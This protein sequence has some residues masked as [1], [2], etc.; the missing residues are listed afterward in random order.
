MKAIIL[1][2]GRG[3]RMG[4]LTADHPKGMI[5]VKGKSLLEWQMEALRKAGVHD[6]CIVRGYLGHAIPFRDVVYRE[7][8]QWESTNMVSSLLAASDVLQS[9]SC[10]V[11]YAD[12]IY[13]DSTVE[14]LLT[15]AGNIRIT[16]DVNWRDLWQRR[17]ANPL[18]DAE[19][20]RLHPDGTV[21]GIGEKP[22]HIDDVQG[23]Y[24]GLLYF[25]PQG[26]RHVR[27]HLVQ[28]P[29]EV[30]QKLDMT[31]LLR[32]LLD[33]MPIHAIPIRD[34]WFEFDS[35]SDINEFERWEIWK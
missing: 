13:R 25:T 2:A 34:T 23:Q 10:V 19:T 26:W 12:I 28:L 14:S 21:A 16:Y 30:V 29:P 31:S 1:A 18:D 4:N 11:S 9:D 35:E 22:A 17:F 8:R 3:S 33:Q 32:S 27:E 15:G 6:I 5:P 20:F 24:M 7:N